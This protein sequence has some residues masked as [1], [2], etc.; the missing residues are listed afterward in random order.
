M[1]LSRAVVR[2]PPRVGWKPSSIQRVRPVLTSTGS[3]GEAVAETVAAWTSPEGEK[4]SQTASSAND[5]DQSRQPWIPARVELDQYP[6][7][8][9]LAW[10]V[11]GS[12]VLTPA[13]ALRIY[14]RNWRHVDAA[15]LTPPERNLI[16]A[17]HIAFGEH[18][19]TKDASHDI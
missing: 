13:E 15:T 18:A 7:L 12:N 11:Q 14:E 2:V 1:S 4:R 17:L 3:F 6:Q 8:K 10:Q 5:N 9:L 19:Q 16:D